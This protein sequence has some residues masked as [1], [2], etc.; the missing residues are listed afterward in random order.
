M[1]KSTT[2]A[3][4]TATRN[5]P[6]AGLTDLLDEFFAFWWEANPTHATAVGIHTHDGEL[7]R[8]DAATLDERARHF[9]TYL[10]AFERST[11]ADA[12][13]WIDRELVLDRIRWELYALDHV[14]PHR[15]DPLVYLEG[16]FGALYHMAVRDYA[17]AAERALRAAERLQ[18]LH[19]ALDQARENLTPREA[20][21]LLV[22]TAAAVARSGL[23]L[24]DSL[25]PVHLGKALEDDEQQFARWENARRGA[26]DALVAFARWLDEELGPQ[27]AGSFAIGREAW[28][29]R[30]RYEHGLHYTAEEILTYG[31][32]LKRRTEQALDEVARE[33]GGRSWR[34]IADA[35][36]GEHPAADELIDAY[37]TEMA[38]ARAF[39]EERELVTIPGDESLRVTATPEFLRPLIPY[40]A[41]QPPAVHEVDQTGLFYVTPPEADD[42]EERL[43]DHSRH[44]IPV[45]ALHEAYPGHHLQL[46]RSNDASSEPRRVFFTSVFAEG[47]ALYC[48]ELMWE[49]GFYTDPRQRLLQLKDLLW[50]ACRVVVDVGLHV[51]GWTAEQAVDYMVAE[52]GLERSNAEIEVRRYCASPTQPMSYAVGKREILRL[53]DRYCARAGN[54]FRL[55]D[56]HDRLLAW[57]TIPPPMIARALGLA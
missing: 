26:G 11:P 10:Q 19:G 14:R 20:A 6:D 32:R 4:R 37:A 57:G 33:L 8:T 27:A 9:R 21:P 24:L 55:R 56:F 16:A 30:V 28:E 13:E 23:V 43:R 41:Y 52:A 48:E 34:E 36:K 51:H 49:Q 29:T 1:P 40:A 5:P 54:G 22:R 46:L 45:T 15:R 31:E 35:L 53:R 17:P 18:A 25:L 39:V 7:E 50:R 42:A 38:R 47:W 12:G 44:G 3:E 2:V